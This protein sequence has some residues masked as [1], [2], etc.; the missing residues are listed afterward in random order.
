MTTTDIIKLLKDNEYGA[1]SH[2]PREISLTIN[3]KYMP[4]P[5]I[6]LSSTGDGIAGPEIDLD[7]IGEFMTLEQEPCD[8]DTISRQPT[9][10]I[11]EWQKDFREY[12]NMLNIPRDDYKGIMEYINDVPSAQPKT[13]R[14][15]KMVSVYDMIEGKYRMIPYTHKDEEL[16]NPPFY[17]CDCGN[18]SKKPT[19]YCPDCGTKMIDVP[20]VNDGKLSEI[21]T[22]S[23]SEE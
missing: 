10:S 6:A 8:E 1:I 15:K 9:Q 13:G 11:A 23:E 16:S 2:K 7:I 5:S 12:I 22:S 19:H 18:N 21:P 4:N 17:V 3:G 14:W 20:Y